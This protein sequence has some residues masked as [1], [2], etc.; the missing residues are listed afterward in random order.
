MSSQNAV[1]WVIGNPEHKSAIRTETRDVSRI[2][3]TGED[4]AIAS[5]QRVSDGRIAG[6]FAVE[7]RENFGRDGNHDDAVKLSVV[8]RTAAAN[9]EKWLFSHTRLQGCADIS[10]GIALHLR[11][12]IVAVRDGTVAW[13]W[14]YHRGDQHLSIP[15]DDQYAVDRLDVLFKLRQLQKQCLLRSLDLIVGEISKNAADGGEH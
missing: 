15:V 6:K 9:S 10:T 11:L 7:A 5:R 14:K 3:I 4:G 1:L 13:C 2:G 12:E 8:Q